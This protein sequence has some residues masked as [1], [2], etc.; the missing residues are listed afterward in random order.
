MTAA[1]G[2]AFLLLTV[3]TGALV[4]ASPVMGGFGIPSRVRVWMSLTTA[5]ALAPVIQSKVGV[6]PETLFGLVAALT[7]EAVIGIVIGSLLQAVVISTQTAGHFI[8]TQIGFG[9]MRLLNPTGFPVSIMAQFKGYVAMVLFLVINGHH[10]AFKALVASYQLSPAIG[11]ATLPGMKTMVVE[12][13]IKLMILAMQIA[14]PAAAVAF[15]TDAGLAA[16]ARAVP[17]MHVL[18]V[19]FPVKIVFGLMGV[20]IGLPVLLWGVRMSLEISSNAVLTFV[21]GG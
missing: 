20:I 10:V 9:I 15:I 16:V 4:L 6:P 13:T 21:K 18:V 14:A 7:R 5:L 8:D 2:Y 3:R 19:G 12:V 17:Q 11:M 1:F